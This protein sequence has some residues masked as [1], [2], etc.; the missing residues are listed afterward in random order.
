MKVGKAKPSNRDLPPDSHIYGYK[1]PRQT[2]G[3]KEVV[4]QPVKETNV[5]NGKTEKDFTKINTFVNG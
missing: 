1:P 3:V 2:E 4:H 5:K